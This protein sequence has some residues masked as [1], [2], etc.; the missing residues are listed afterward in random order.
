MLS[1]LFQAFLH[2]SIAIDLGTANTRVYASSHGQFAETSSSISLV[3]NQTQDLSDEYL[4]YLN[5]RLFAKPLRGGV[6][7]D[8]KNTIKLLKPLIRERKKHLMPPVALASAPM[9]TTDKERDLLRKAIVD[10]GA[11]RVAIMPEVWVAAIG[12]GVDITQQKAQLLIDIGDGVTD[13]A[14]FRDGRIIYSSSI[15]VACSDFQKAVRSLIVSKYK[16]QLCDNDVEKLT[17]TIG[18]ISSKDIRNEEVISLS[19]I[20]IIQRRKVNFN[21]RTLDIVNSVEPITDKILKLIESGLK[22]IPEK[23]HTEIIETGIYLT[24]GGACIEGMDKLIESKTNIGVTVPSDP[25]HAVINGA[26]QTLN[27]WDGKKNWWENIA[28]PNLSS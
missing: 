17:N 10:A 26:I 6:I 12:A 1:K 13:M 2:P 15:R 23:I 9:D 8:L 22:K 18:F 28:W 14:V 5:N 20:D 21:V 24:G 3:S 4:R 11:S 19:G 7:V 16:I 25:I 27:Y